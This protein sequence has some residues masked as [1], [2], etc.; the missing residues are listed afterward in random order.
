MAK[1][2]AQKFQEYEPGMT[3]TEELAEDGNYKAVLASKGKPGLKGWRKSDPK[4][5]PYRMLNFRLL[6]TEG[7][8][9]SELRVRYILTS[10]PKA[11]GL[12]Q[13]LAIAAGFPEKLRLPVPKKSTDPEV[14]ERCEALDQLVDYMEE[15]EVVVNVFITTEEYKGRDTNRV[16]MDPPDDAAAEG[17][18]EETE[19]LEEEE[20]PEA[21]EESEEADEDEEEAEE[22]DHSEPDEEDAE[23]E[24]EAVPVKR[25]PGRPKGSKTKA[26]VKVAPKKRR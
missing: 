16:R 24:E 26:P 1:G 7:Q 9:G 21:E 2:E 17:E 10:S 6:G 3:R 14:A 19:E 5:F 18:A 15:N 23:V 11:F 12:V 4:K 13:D 22:Y 20:E 25:G 8:D